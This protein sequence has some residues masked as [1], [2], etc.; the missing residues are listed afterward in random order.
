MNHS[1]IHIESKPKTAKPNVP[2]FGSA[3]QKKLSVGSANDTYEVE[4]DIMADKV[5]RMQE[6]QQG[7]VSYSGSLVQRKCAH[8]EEEEKIQKKLLADNITPLIQRSSNSEDG[9]HASDYVENQINS[10]KGGGS[11]MDNGTKKFMESRFGID[12]SG[13]RIHTGSQAVQMSREL[14]AQ[15]FT[16][17]NDVYFNEGKYNPNSE[18]GRHLLAH[19]LTHTVQQGDEINRKIIQKSC[20]ISEIGI[21]VGCTGETSV[22]L[23]EGLK[24]L[25]NVNCDEFSGDN[26][27]DLRI[28][29]EHYNNGDTIEIHG[30]S[31]EEGPIDF[32]VNLSCARAIKAKEIIENVAISKGFHFN[33]IVYSHGPQNVGSASL[34]R[35]VLIVQSGNIVPPVIETETPPVPE[36]PTGTNDCSD[37]AYCTPYTTSTE[38]I[39][40]RNYLLTYFIP[41]LEGYFGSDVGD[42]W[43]SFLSRRPGDSLSPRVFDTAGNS[44]YE[45]FSNNNYISDEVDNVLDLVSTR[46]SRGYGNVTQRI[47]NFISESEKQ[48]STNFAN[49]Y[50]IPGNIAGGIGSSDAGLDSRRIT[51]GNVSFNITELPLG[52]RMVTIEV[53]LNFEVKD[54]IDFCPGDCGAILEQM[55]ATIKMSRLEAS[56]EAYDVP[57]VVRFPGPRRTKTV[58]V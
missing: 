9:N 38:I 36:I 42:L 58:F 10:S 51:W 45:S 6:S 49:A 12:F 3:I 40:A 4:A 18:S 5:M 28:S 41:I 13:V 26:G 7:T 55:L 11:S 15:A 46:L 2:F 1:P 33:I 23:P 20:G 48:L 37:P 47:E 16:V 39:D 35:S 57:F 56:R 32:N 53:F 31:S 25:F 22:D 29:A 8:C 44:I 34:N 27:R 43:R 50:T 21:P 14:N 54:A 24:Y 30:L 17:G 52:S 19:E